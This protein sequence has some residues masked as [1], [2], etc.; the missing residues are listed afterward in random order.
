MLAWLL[1]LNQDIERLLEKVNKRKVK[2]DMQF[3]RLTAVRLTWCRETWRYKWI[4]SC[5]CE[6]GK[7]T[8]VLASDL[9]S[10][11]T[12]SCGCLGELNRQKMKDFY[13]PAV[14]KECGAEYRTNKHKQTRGLCLK[15]GGRK[16]KREWAR[17]NSQTQNL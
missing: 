4:C 6:E 15:C 11:N 13:Q 1:R 16:S 14:C 5:S 10:G 2:K 12:S 9:I 7:T 17:R 8:S 3:G